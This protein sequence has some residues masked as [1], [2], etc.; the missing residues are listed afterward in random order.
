MREFPE[1]TRRQ[2]A[3]DALERM[4]TCDGNGT[5]S[6]EQKPRSRVLS[7]FARGKGHHQ[8]ARTASV[9]SLSSSHPARW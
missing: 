4:H 8:P 1:L 2:R 3:L 5:H 9:E 7:F 6:R